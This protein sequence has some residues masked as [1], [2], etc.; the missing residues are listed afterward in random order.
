MTLHTADQKGNDAL[1]T[2]VEKRLQTSDVALFAPLPKAKLKTFQSL[3]KSKN[4]KVAKNDIIIKAKRGVFA[5][6][7]FM[8]QHRRMNMQD[9]LKYPLGPLPWSI[10]TPDGASAKT[11]K[12]TLLH[13][14]HGKAE[15]VEAVPSS[16]V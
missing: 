13:I 14:L 6:M 15:A 2:Y 12:A 3:V 10:A 4:N 7:V 11:E 1:T 5:R 8:A 9:V 16:G